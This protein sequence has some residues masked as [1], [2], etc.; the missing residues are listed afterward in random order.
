MAWSRK[1]KKTWAAVGLAFIGLAGARGLACHALRPP[2]EAVVQ[3]HDRS[4]VLSRRDYLLARVAGNFER[5]MAAPDQ[6][7]FRGE[8]ALGTLSMTSAAICNIAFQWPDTRA[9]ALDQLPRLIDKALLPST[10]AFD[11]G[12]WDSDALE[13]LGTE[14][15]HLGYL[16]HLNLMLGCYRVI[17]G[18]ARYDDLHDR[19]TAAMAR[20]MDRSPS[21]HVETYPGEIYT[22]DNSTA[23]ASVAVHGIATGK[24]HGPTLR[25]F[26]HYTRNHLL[27]P[28]TGLVVFKVDAEGHPLGTSRGC[29]VGWNSFY[30]PFVD[31]A[32]ASDQWGK[33]RTHMIRRS[34]VGLWG[35]REFADDVAGS[36]DVDSG[37]LIL[38]LSPSATGFSIAGARRENDVES[39]GRLMLTAEAAGTTWVGLDGS[40][41]LAAPLVGDAIVLAMRTAHAWDGRY[42][43]A[44]PHAANLRRSTAFVT[45]PQ[46]VP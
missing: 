30:L 22:S 24:D 12:A 8:W 26:V 44:K 43:P 19:L 39:L 11:T 10:R 9:A 29:G 41:Y 37:P 15:G 4:D 45:T 32:F 31:P 42:L 28:A 20:R 34:A 17:G 35:V 5:E 3:G 14:Q 33:L 40:R 46:V 23:A 18:D 25:K 2:A 6:G 16:G 21:A 1:T 38:G 7:F 27:D 36:G 13:S